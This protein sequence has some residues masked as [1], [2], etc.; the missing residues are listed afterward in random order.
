[1]SS[2]DQGGASLFH[3]AQPNTRPSTGNLFRDVS[4]ISADIM[5]VERMSPN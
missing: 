3:I 2:L 4:D 5:Q 1:M